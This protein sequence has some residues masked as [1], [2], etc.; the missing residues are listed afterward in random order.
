MP[1]C[2]THLI[3]DAQERVVRR[4]RTNF[5]RIPFIFSDLA[6]LCLTHS[7]PFLLHDGT[8]NP[9]EMHSTHLVGFAHAHPQEH[10]RAEDKWQ[11]MVIFLFLKNGSLPRRT[12][13]TT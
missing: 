12:L 4:D 1:H 9:F 5:A 2:C 3:I 6:L 11:T 8:Q 13:T 7:L 10:H